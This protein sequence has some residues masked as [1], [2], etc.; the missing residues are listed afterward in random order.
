MMGASDGPRRRT[1]GVVLI[2]AA[3]LSAGAAC[4]DFESPEDPTGGLPD[5][6]I[7]HPSFTRDIAPIFDRR[8]ATGGCH[9]PAT[10]RAGLVLTE[11]AVY[12]EIVGVSARHEGFL[13]VAPGNADTSW[14]VRM[15]EPDPARRHGLVRMPLASTPLT[16]NQ[17]ENI[18]RWID[19]GAPRN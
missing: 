12:E 18:R 5:L 7:E 10:Q 13:L 11:D 8:C 9:S 16:P 6:L 4:A 3:G 17:I 19:Q 2:L 14:I 15:I 1:A